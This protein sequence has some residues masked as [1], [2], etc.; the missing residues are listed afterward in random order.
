MDMEL[1]ELETKISQ[2]VDAIH[3]LRSENRLLRQQI[4]AKTDDVKRL[5]EKIETDKGRLESVLKHIPEKA[6]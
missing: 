6:I 5:S 3:H 4:A 1:A 2:L